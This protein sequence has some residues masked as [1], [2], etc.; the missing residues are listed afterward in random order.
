MEPLRQP[1][2]PELS[3]LEQGDHSHLTRE[4]EIQRVDDMAL[5]QGTT[6]ASFA[7]LDEKK[8]LRKVVLFPRP[9]IG[10]G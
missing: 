7:D 3:E 8:I 10:P 1:D 2:K 5:A 4:E 9:F 6:L